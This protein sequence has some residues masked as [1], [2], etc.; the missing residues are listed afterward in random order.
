MR[1]KTKS[2]KSTPKYILNPD[3][4]GSEEYEKE[5]ESFKRQ[6]IQ[7][8][9]CVEDYF[10]EDYGKQLPEDGAWIMLLM[11][12][13]VGKPLTQGKSETIEVPHLSVWFATPTVSQSGYREVRPKKAVIQTPQGEVHIWPHEY[14]VV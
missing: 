8:W 4:L 3:Y 10:P 6:L 2:R 12:V 1:A 13:H 7:R 9:E 11:S 5:K 14:T